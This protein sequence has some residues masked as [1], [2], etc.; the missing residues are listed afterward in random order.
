MRWKG[1]RIS[2]NVEDRR[3]GGAAKAGGISI[4][5]LIVAFVAWKFFGVDPQMAYQA[6]KS[7]TQQQQVSDQAPQ[8]LTP[9]QEE[10]SEFV[11]TVLADTEDTWS[12]IFKQLGGTYTPPKLVMFSG[13]IRSGCGTAQAAMGPFYCPADQKVYIDTAFFK[14]MRQ[15]MGI[16][17]EQNQTELSRQDQAGDF[18]QAYVIAHEVGHHVQNL[19]GISSQV[20]QAQSQGSRTQGNQLSVRLELQADCFSGIWANHN[21]QRTQF[22]EQGDIEEAM[23]AAQKIG[24]DYL[25]K[26]AT[27]QVVPD[28]FTHGTSQQRMHWFQVG[29]KTGDLNQCNTFESNL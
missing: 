29:L 22:L 3:G 11:G 19:L 1:R 5:G 25:Q 27:G 7:V 28:S 14:E 10:A 6:T 17:G 4:L 15:Q 9:E 13:A 24:D 26:Q 23:D 8:Q 21:E 2:T 16:S 20:Q 12:P 18:A